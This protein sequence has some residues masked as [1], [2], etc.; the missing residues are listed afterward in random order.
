MNGY[1]FTRREKAI[2]M[3]LG[4]FLLLRLLITLIIFRGRVA[5]AGTVSRWS[6]RPRLALLT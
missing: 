3:I 2:L 1:K 4:I 5:R 6:P